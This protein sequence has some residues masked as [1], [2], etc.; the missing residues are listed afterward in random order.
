M[1]PAY[2]LTWQRLYPGS[3]LPPQAH[4]CAV[5]AKLQIKPCNHSMLSSTQY[6]CTCALP[7]ILSSSLYIHHVHAT[8]CGGGMHTKSGL[9]A[10]SQRGPEEEGK[11]WRG[12]RKGRHRSLKWQKSQNH[13]LGLFRGICSSFCF[14]VHPQVEASRKHKSCEGV[15]NRPLDGIDGVEEWEQQRYQPNKESCMNTP[16][17][18]YMHMHKHYIHM[19]GQC[20]R[21]SHVEPVFV[22]ARGIDLERILQYCTL[23]E[24]S[25]TELS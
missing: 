7:C 4:C 8:I 20:R 11:G 3:I 14:A 17:S 12:G 10:A 22:S 5:H 9:F 2:S 18:V 13:S 15:A 21:R 19:A 24:L 23:T 1:W 25:F 16:E 6:S